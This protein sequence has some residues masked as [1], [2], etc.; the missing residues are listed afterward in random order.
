MRKI[1]KRGTKE[2]V[3]CNTCGCRFSYEEEDV[4]KPDDT[5]IW[6][7]MNVSLIGD[8]KGGSVICPQCSAKIRVGTIVK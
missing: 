3:T 6:P 8:N 2:I 4:I 5:Q 7:Q 1:I